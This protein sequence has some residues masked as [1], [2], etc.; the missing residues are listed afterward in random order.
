MGEC[1]NCGDSEGLLNILLKSNETEDMPNNIIFKQWLTIG[2]AAMVTVMK[3]RDEYFE[4]LVE[5]INN[6]KP[7]HYVLKIHSASFKDMKSTVTKEEC[8]VVADFF[9]KLLI[10]RTG[11]NPKY[12]LGQKTS[13]YSSVFILFLW[14]RIWLGKM[15]KH[16][17]I[18]NYLQHTTPVVHTFQKHIAEDIKCITPAIKK[19]FISPIGLPAN[20][21]IKTLS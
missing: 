8:V 6:L 3:P 18:R 11:W 4:S 17:V 15:S 1:E 12:S 20:T 21:R 19:L 2:W 16:C 10:H 5:K 14:W 9:W 13:Y 7:H